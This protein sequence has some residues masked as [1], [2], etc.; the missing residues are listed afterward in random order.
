MSLLSKSDE[1][2]EVSDYSEMRN[3]SISANPSFTAIKIVQNV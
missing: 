1:Q 3:V 2:S